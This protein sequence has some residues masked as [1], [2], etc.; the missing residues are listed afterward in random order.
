MGRQKKKKEK[1]IKWFPG[2]DLYITIVIV[3]VVGSVM[4]LKAC[5]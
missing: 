2:H 4:M 1:D 3:I 5:S